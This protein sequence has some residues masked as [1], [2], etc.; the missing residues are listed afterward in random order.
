VTYIPN[1]EHR[2]AIKILIDEYKPQKTRETELKMI[3]L[4]K[5]DEP[6][7]QTAR[8]LSPIEREQVNAQVDTSGHARAMCNIPYQNM[9][10]LSC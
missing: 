4:L 10:V 3:I 7:C 6:V 1:T 8:R 9:R 2:D 5:D